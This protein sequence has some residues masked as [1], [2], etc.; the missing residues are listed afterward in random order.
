MDVYKLAIEVQDASNISGVVHSLSQVIQFIRDNDPIKGNAYLNSHPAIVLFVNKLSS[1]TGGDSHDNFSRA[2]KACQEHVE[3]GC[4]TRCLVPEIVPVAGW[5]P[6]DDADRRNV[7]RYV[8]APE[9]QGAGPHGGD[10]VRVLPAGGD[11]NA[12]LCRSC[13]GREM[14]FRLDRN[15]ENFAKAT[16]RHSVPP[17]DIPTWESLKVYDAGE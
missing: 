10:E 4:T 11:S 13:F 15:R 7:P 2:Y 1:F 9:C 6:Q 17:F 5:T 12:I 8:I 16:T 14:M 3:F